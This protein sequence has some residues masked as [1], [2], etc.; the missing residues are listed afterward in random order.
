MLVAVCGCV[1]LWLAVE[2]PN[3]THF[4]EYSTQ[5]DQ[6]HRQT[7]PQFYG[8]KKCSPMKSKGGS[9]NSI[10]QRC[11]TGNKNGGGAVG[12]GL[13]FEGQNYQ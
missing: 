1:G 4:V 2:Y 6:N 8:K 13:R 10:N 12:L 3:F 11:V 5:P 9:H 7:L